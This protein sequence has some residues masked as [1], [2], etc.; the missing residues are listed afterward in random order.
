MYSNITYLGF[1][2]KS[3]IINELKTC[4]AFIFSSIWY[5]GNPLTI[6][7]ALASGTAVI[8]SKMGAMQ[9]MITDGYNGL[10]FTPGDEGNLIEK[11]NDW[12]ALSQQSK[13]SFY[14]NARQTY[15][16]NY[17]PVKNFDKLISIYKSVVNHGKTKPVELVC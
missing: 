2:D 12:Q 7:E 10:H 5:E 6:I 14:E 4:T 1:K 16:S 11:L 3:S 8:A 13:D 15:V 9:T 17:T